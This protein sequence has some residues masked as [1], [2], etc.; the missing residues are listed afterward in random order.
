M[1]DDRLADGHVV[2]TGAARGIGRGIAVRAA[3]A[4][5]TVTIFDVNTE[6]AETTAEFVR[7]EGVS[8]SVR[9]VDVSD[10][11]AVNDAFAAA[12]EEFGPVQ[13]L[14]NSAGVQRAVPIRKTTETDW[15]RHMDV[16]AKGVFFCSKTAAERMVGSGVEGSIVNITSVGAI[17]PFSG[18]G[19]YAASKAAR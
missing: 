15:D 4:G 11:A 12:E 2:V 13:G 14:V 1:Q 5:A 7:D 9:A 18:Q 8:A 10:E 6:D 17:Q 3:R 16:N 19:A